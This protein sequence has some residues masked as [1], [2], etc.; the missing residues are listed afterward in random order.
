M[1]KAGETRLGF[2]R[3]HTEIAWVSH[4]LS[5][6]GSQLGTHIRLFKVERGFWQRE[7]FARPLKELREQNAAGTLRPRPRWIPAIK[8]PLW[9]W[10]W[11]LFSF[12]TIL[13]RHAAWVVLVTP[14]N[15]LPVILHFSLPLCEQ[16]AFSAAPALSMCHAAEKI[17]K[18]QNSRIPPSVCGSLSLKDREHLPSKHAWMMLDAAAPFVVLMMLKLVQILALARFYF[19]HLQHWKEK[20]K[21]GIKDTYC[22]FFFFCS[23]KSLPPWISI[24]T[25]TVM[26]SDRERVPK[27]HPVMQT[28]THLHPWLHPQQASL[29]ARFNSS[30]PNMK[31]EKFCTWNGK[32]NLSCIYYTI[33]PSVHMLPTHIYPCTHTHTGRASSNTSTVDPIIQ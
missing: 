28:R 12:A 6:S 19:P 22:E 16:G 13:H 25:W 23:S 17:I 31:R 29:P 30:P 10:H 8:R 5:M 3:S 15:V 14:S 4:G 2:A 21:W 1:T 20:K 9:Q 32:V 33:P 24:H 26:S 27:H 7:A 18:R 11:F